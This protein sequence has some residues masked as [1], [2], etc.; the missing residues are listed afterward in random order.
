MRLFSLS[1]TVLR[2]LPF[3]FPRLTACP[4]STLNLFLPFTILSFCVT[5]CEITFAR[6][7]YLSNFRPCSRYGNS[8]EI[9][10]YLT[11][12]QCICMRTVKQIVPRQEVAKDRSAGF[13]SC[14]ELRDWALKI[15][16]QVLFLS[17]WYAIAVSFCRLF[18]EKFRGFFT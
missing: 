1:E 3:P 5:L 10:K 2:V 15:I 17:N 9:E 12:K 14:S 11:L 6:G 13:L 8:S 16:W 7:N 18:V 4:T